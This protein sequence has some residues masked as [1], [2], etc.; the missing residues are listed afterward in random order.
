LAFSTNPKDI[1]TWEGHK[2]YFMK[3]EHAWVH[4]AESTKRD[5]YFVLELLSISFMKWDNLSFSWKPGVERRFWW[6]FR[7]LVE[8]RRITSDFHN[9]AAWSGHQRTC[10]LQCDQHRHLQTI[11][12]KGGSQKM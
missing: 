1:K 6:S 8:L 4:L 5:K 7:H 3:L 9:Q 12:W 10:G 2:T 11:V